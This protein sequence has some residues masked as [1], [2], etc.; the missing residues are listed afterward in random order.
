MQKY[1]YRGSNL[2]TA[3][4]KIGFL[5]SCTCWMRICVY[6]S[7]FPSVNEWV[8]RRR[9]KIL[10]ICRVVLKLNETVLLLFYS[11]HF[12]TKDGPNIREEQSLKKPRQG[13]GL[14]KYVPDRGTK[15]D[16]LW[17]LLIQYISL[18]CTKTQQTQYSQICVDWGKRKEVQERIAGKPHYSREKIQGEVMDI[19]LQSILSKVDECLSSIFLDLP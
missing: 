5:L 16:R 11:N 15:G 12:D 3:M 8:K 14:R 7:S 1:G 13:G 4:K 10:T 6:L 9:A 17:E 18:K 19:F 2:T